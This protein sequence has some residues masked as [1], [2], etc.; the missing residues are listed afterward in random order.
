[1]TERKTITVTEDAYER[2]LDHKSEGESWAQVFD[3][4]ADALE[5]QDETMNTTAVTNVDEI[6]RAAADEVEDRMTRR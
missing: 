6:A 3:R 1:M 2:L 4:A 5:S